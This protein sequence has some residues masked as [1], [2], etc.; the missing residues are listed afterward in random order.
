MYSI[1]GLQCKA[2]YEFFDLCWTG[3]NG[4]L[5]DNFLANP[6]GFYKT[7]LVPATL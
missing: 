7:P 3:V 5:L 4:Y 6:L 1:G 2:R